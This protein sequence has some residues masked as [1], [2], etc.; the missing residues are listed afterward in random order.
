MTLVVRPGMN[1]IR[2]DSHLHYLVTLG[3]AFL[4][5]SILVSVSYLAI[6]NEWGLAHAFQNN[7]VNGAP[8]R[9]FQGGLV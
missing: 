7:K 3:L 9:N 5:H 6:L 8:V 2:H 1:I 4:L